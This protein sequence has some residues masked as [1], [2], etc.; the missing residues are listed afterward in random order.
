M[1]IESQVIKNLV[2]LGYIARENNLEI[3]DI[4]EMLEQGFV[5]M[6]PEHRSR[7]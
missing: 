4:I 7:S 3:E 6:Q 5:A 2:S 1:K